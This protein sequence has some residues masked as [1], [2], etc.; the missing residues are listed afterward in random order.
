MDFNS[1]MREAQKIQ[2]EMQRKDAELKNKEY[3]STKSKSIVEVTM[4]G[5]YELTSVKIND[6]FANNFTSD[7]REILEDALM[8]AVNEVT[9]KVTEDKEGLVGDL[10]GSLN[11]PGL[12]L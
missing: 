7:D 11:I 8:L 10:A 5:D 12:G 4:N 9:A 6:E 3:T 1:L 2:E